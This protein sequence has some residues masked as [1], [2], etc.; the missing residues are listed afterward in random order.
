MTAETLR[1]LSIIAFSIAAAALIVGAVLWFTLNIKG[2]IDFLTGRNVKKATENFGSSAG[3]V[4]YKRPTGGVPRQSKSAGTAKAKNEKVR[5]KGPKKSEPTM[6]LADNEPN[7]SS[8]MPNSEPTTALSEGTMLLDN[9]D[10]VEGT[11]LLDDSDSVEGTALLDDS[12]PID[13]TTLLDAQSA[14]HSSFVITESIVIVH[15][16]EDIKFE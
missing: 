9:S 13:G 5:K 10:S 7:A 8:T 12:D 4:L 1:T 2:V 15:T 16:D 14:K 3:R 11:A 6:P